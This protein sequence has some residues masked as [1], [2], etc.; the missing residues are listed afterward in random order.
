MAIV[1]VE[2]TNVAVALPY[3]A[4]AAPKRQEYSL[5]NRHSDI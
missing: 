5:A 3:V 2:N 1:A 4:V